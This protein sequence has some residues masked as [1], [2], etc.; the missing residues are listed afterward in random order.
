MPLGR[1][2]QSIPFQELIERVLAR[3][4]ATTFKSGILTL[5]VRHLKHI[6]IFLTYLKSPIPC[7]QNHK[8][9]WEFQGLMAKGAI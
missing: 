6:K 8:A 2:P 1:N 3:L 9:D 7:F 5:S 4:A